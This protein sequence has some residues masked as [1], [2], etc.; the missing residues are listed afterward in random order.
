[1]NSKIIESLADRLHNLEERMAFYEQRFE[2]L[3]RDLAGLEALL[4]K[5]LEALDIIDERINGAIF[6]RKES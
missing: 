2:K 5:V 4:K 3:E 1:M 6:P